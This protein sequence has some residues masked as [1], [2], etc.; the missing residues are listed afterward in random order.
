MNMTEKRDD[1]Q[2]KGQ[3]WPPPPANERPHERARR[4][5]NRL[6][7]GIDSRRKLRDD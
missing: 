7:Y 5:M 6:A 4:A 1:Q 3:Q 2:P